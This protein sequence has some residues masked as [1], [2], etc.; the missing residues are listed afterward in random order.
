[1]HRCQPQVLPA[2]ALICLFKQE[3]DAGNLVLSSTHRATTMSMRDLSTST[4]PAPAPYS[5]PPYRS[6]WPAV[7][8]GSKSGNVC[9]SG[10]VRSGGLG[11]GHASECIKDWIDAAVLPLAGRSKGSLHGVHS[12][13][14]SIGL[15]TSS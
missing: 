15:Q 11:G 8:D 14:N 4:A 12:A 2:P 3:A 1:V 5:V 7:H 9:V 13:T 10:R 6:F